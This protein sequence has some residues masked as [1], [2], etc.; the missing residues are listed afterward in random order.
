LR[1]LLRL[2]ISRSSNPPTFNL[3]L[4]A[5]TKAFLTALCDAFH[6][7]SIGKSLGGRCKMPT[8][9]TSR[10]TRNVVIALVVLAFLLA[11]LVVRKT[12][13]SE[14]PMSWN[15]DS[16]RAQM[17]ETQLIYRGI[18]DERVLVAMRK[19]PRHRFVPERI[20]HR[21]YEDNALPIGEDQTISQPYIVAYMT[22]GLKL[23]G[24]EKVL[25]VGTGSGYE[26]AVLAEIGCEVYTIEIIP[27]LT[28]VARRQLDEAGYPQVHTR[29]G[30]GY[31]GWPEEAPFDA[32]I[33]T[34][35]PTKVPTALFEQLKP[36]GRMI[37][38]VGPEY[39]VQNLLRLTK[40]EAGQVKTDTLIPV[41]FVPMTGE[42]ERKK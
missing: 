2:A 3:G 7:E 9:T 27:E 42:I 23:S 20:E 40:T 4:K 28:Q 15:P 31:F 36:G 21:A 8:E 25:E 1:A 24:G 12:V 41:I 14:E 22:E 33:I 34:A 26:A 16:L 39:G 5:K 29:T 19:I 35:A 37:V 11:V 18:K 32:I 38:P 10:R 6:D 13:M 17:V 30:D